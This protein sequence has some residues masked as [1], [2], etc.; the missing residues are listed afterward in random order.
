MLKSTYQRPGAA[1]VLALLIT[2]FVFQTSLFVAANSQ[3]FD[4]AVHVA[5]GQQYLEKREWQFN[6]EHPPL[7]KLLSALPAYLTYDLPPLD[8]TSDQ[9]SAGRSYLYSSTQ[10]AGKLLTLARVSNVILGALTVFLIA[11]WSWQLWGAYGAILST[12]LAAFDPNLIAHSGVATTDMGA[13]F[14]FMLTLYLL[15]R[16]LR[17]TQWRSLAFAG[18]ALGCALGSKF[19]TITLLPTIGVVLLARPL[20]PT[21]QGEPTKGRLQNLGAA[22]GTI[23]ILLLIAELAL[24]A[25]Y[26]GGDLSIWLDGIRDQMHHQEAGHPAYFFGSYRTTGWLWY[27]P[28]AFLMKTPLATL[29]ALACTLA[30]W[31]KLVARQPEM[32]L[33]IGVAVSFFALAAC[34]SHVNIG[35]RYL[36]PGYALTFVPIGVLATLPFRRA[37]QRLLCCVA[38]VSAA[39]A[40]SLSVAPNQLAFFNLAFGGPSRGYKYLSDSNLDWGQDLGKLADWLE[41]QGNPTIY[42]AYFGSAPPASFGIQYQWLP[43]F[44]NS[45][46]QEAWQ[47]PW[48]G[49]QELLATSMTNLQGTY[50]D[51]HGTHEWLFNREPVARIGNS[52]RVYNI[53]GDPA[54]HQHLKQIYQHALM[55]EWAQREQEKIDRSEKIPQ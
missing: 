4:E 40:A 32:S 25:C 52:I 42:L 44:G 49:R 41:D 23:A 18:I 5:A 34:L 3:T 31:R 38:L 29:T 17:R 28:L 48:D 12:G 47:V 51:D 45:P 15:W 16:Y 54:A 7:T 43:T 46:S 50:L 20:L 10:P 36:L 21:G 9:W 33:I 39:A 24:W 30:C 55:T 14:F 1:V 2:S 11:C 27:F 35:V 13:T 6:R 8:A 37:W 26:L 19:S 53:A 22:A